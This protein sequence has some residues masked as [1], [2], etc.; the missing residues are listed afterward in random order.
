MG[1]PGCF[2]GRPSAG[3][4]G[5]NDWAPAA[6]GLPLKAVTG[7]VLAF[8]GPIQYV[9][10]AQFTPEVLP[11][12]GSL[13]TSPPWINAVRAPRAS[14]VA[15]EAPVISGA[16]GLTPPATQAMQAAECED[17]MGEGS[18]RY[19]AYDWLPCT[20]LSGA[21]PNRLSLALGCSLKSHPQGL[22]PLQSHYGRM[23][24]L[25]AQPALAFAIDE[26]CH[27]Y[28]TR[29]NRLPDFPTRQRDGCYIAPLP[30]P[31]EAKPPPTSLSEPFR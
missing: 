2:G 9:W 17:P 19:S 16:F 30:N 21:K 31:H 23:G 28:R 22:K 25:R 27:H 29:T 5:P 15:L 10:V 20:S 14:D 11:G 8:Y 1:L 12:K 26:S 18:T 6:S 4:T 3:T 7:I 13:S 24:H